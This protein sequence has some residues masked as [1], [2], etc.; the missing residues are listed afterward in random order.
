MTD[1]DTDTDGGA[2]TAGEHLVEAAKEGGKA[3]TQAARKVADL[4]LS[5]VRGGGGGGRGGG[6]PRPDLSG[7]ISR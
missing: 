2:T 4:A 1:T 7:G 3:V 6:G 5:V